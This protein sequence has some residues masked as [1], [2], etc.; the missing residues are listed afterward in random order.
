LLGD[1]VL[2]ACTLANLTPIVADARDELPA[3]PSGHIGLGDGMTSN[4]HREVRV[5]DLRFGRTDD[6]PVPGVE[7]R[8]MRYHAG[9]VVSGRIGDLR[10]DDAWTKITA[11]A[12]ASGAFP[13]AFTPVV[14]ERAAHEFGRTWPAALKQ[15]GITRYPFTYV[16]GGMFNNEPI[17]E[18]F[19]LAS[20]LDGLT[21]EPDFDRLIVFVDPNIS[22]L[23]GKAVLR[24][25]LHSEFSL[26]GPVE[27]GFLSNACPVRKP[28][29]DRMVPIAVS[30]ANSIMNE[31]RVVEA[32]R[33]YATAAYVNPKTKPHKA[34]L[35]AI[36]PVHDPAGEALPIELPGAALSGF[37]GFMSTL[38]GEFEMEAGRRCARQSLEACGVIQSDDALAPPALSL[39]R[40]SRARFNRD[41]SRGIAQL[42]GRVEQMIRDTRLVDLGPAG[43]IVMRI[44]ARCARRRFQAAANNAMKNRNHRSEFFE[45]WIQVP[46]RE[47][48]L[49][50][51]QCAAL[52]PVRLD[53]DWWLMT[54]VE[55]D[56]TRTARPWSGPYVCDGLL[57]VH[58]NGFMR[59]R[60]FCELRLPEPK[61]ANRAALLPNPRFMLTI[62]P[63]DHGQ[64]LPPSR[65]SVHPGV[66]PLEHQLFR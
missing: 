38:A 56:A 43:G 47:F 64:T 20:Y 19:R 17:R 2:F 28:S 51:S 8:W 46:S 37:A 22:D 41:V 24:V 59:D 7:G 65:W 14:L 35:V 16:D 61:T 48:R 60:L 33:V 21:P 23:R 31:S 58:Q 45:L 49:N 34:K 62:A 9:A 27:G 6:A 55:R 53:H 39:P 50:S 54:V 4:V 52:K 44:L 42:A 26:K 25:P 29:L 5:F 30:V 40:E 11:T 13:M 36:A 3:H 57:K 10:S 12:I 63:T 18:A 15:A 1:R 32:D 66:E